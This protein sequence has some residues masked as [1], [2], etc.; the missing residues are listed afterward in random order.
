VLKQLTDQLLSLTPL[1]GEQV[2]LAVAELVDEK[3]APET[4]ADF[5][6]ALAQKGETPEEIAAFAREL[7]ER[8]LPVPLDA[9]TRAR[10]IL[11]VVG[12]GGDRLGTF[13]I[14]TTVAL[15][16]AAAGVTVAKHGNRAVTSQ[17]GSAD[18]LEAL[19]VRI[20]LTPEQAAQSLREHG[21]AFFFAQKSHPAFKHVAPARKLC[22]ERVNAPSS[23]SLAHC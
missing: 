21:F 8:A 2:A 9:E 13:N 18:V 22:A 19:G 11:D 16:C 10:E 5:L 1:N 6:S 4:K 12:T 23:T 20:D 17:C 14:S 3:I 7:R 15:V